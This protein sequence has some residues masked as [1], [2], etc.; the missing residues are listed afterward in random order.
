MGK[1]VNFYMAEADEEMF[2]DFLR[3][4]REVAIFE[5]AISSPDLIS[6]EKLPS[7]EVPSWFIVWLWDKANS[8]EPHTRYIKEQNY[9]VFDRFRSEIIEL[10]RSHLNQDR[11]VRGR[12]WAEMAWWDE[13]TF[14]RKYKSDSFK[15]WFNRLARWIKKNSIRNEVGDYVMPGAKKFVEGGGKLVQFVT[16]K[17]VSIKFHDI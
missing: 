15:K 4:D 5:Y 3:S 8:P 16:G 10:S 13:V 1:Q 11:L 14:E 7:R 12:I 9:Y 6:L 17:T 2:I